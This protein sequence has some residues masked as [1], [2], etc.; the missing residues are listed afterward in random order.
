MARFTPI[1][2]EHLSAIAS[3]FDDLDAR[4]ARP[5]TYGCLERGLPSVSWVCAQVGCKSICFGSCLIGARR[6]AFARVPSELYDGA[7]SAIRRRE[8]LVF[9]VCLSFWDFEA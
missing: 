1:G 6:R 4:G 7:V 9:Q 3:R 5:R 2:N 8:C